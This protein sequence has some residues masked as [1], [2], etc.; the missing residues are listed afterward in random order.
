MWW[1]TDGLAARIFNPSFA[2]SHA[3]ELPTIRGFR[4]RLT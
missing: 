3:F 4:P 1:E 2:Q